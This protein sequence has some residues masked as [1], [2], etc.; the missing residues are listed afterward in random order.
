MTGCLLEEYW[1]EVVVFAQVPSLTAIPAC[2]P[3]FLFDHYPH[4]VDLSW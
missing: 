4:L 3:Y 2:V 1:G